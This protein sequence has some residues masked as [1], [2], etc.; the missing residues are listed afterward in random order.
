MTETRIKETLA[1]SGLG[2]G[3]S[4]LLTPILTRLY[5]P[6][7]YGLFAIINGVATVAASASQFSLTNALACATS[8]ATRWRLTRILVRL[9]LLGCVVTFFSLA[10]FVQ[11]GAAGSIWVQPWIIFGCPLLTFTI[12]AYR[13]AAS[14]SVAQGQFH[15]QVFARIGYALMAR[16]LAILF[17]LLFAPR[18]WFMVIAEAMAFG[19]QLFILSAHNWPRSAFRLISGRPSNVPAA[20]WRHRTFSL[21]DFPSQI[22][23]IAAQAVPAM[24]IGL[25][26]GPG[27]AG[28]LSVGVSLLSI[29]VQLISLAIAPALLYKVRTAWA[30]GSTVAVRALVRAF[31]LLSCLA[32]A[33]YGLLLLIAPWFVPVFLGRQWAE[34]GMLVR[35]LCVPFALQFITTP[36]LS[37]LWYSGH[38]RQKLAVDV[39]GFIAALAAL[40]LAVLGRSAAS[41]IAGWALV[42]TIQRIAELTLLAAGSRR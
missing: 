15:R 5:S 11:L 35:W 20:L 36:F 25:R 2:F 40:S 37:I 3:L 12:C 34:T 41:A 19:A 26:F 27:A 30:D 9:S 7:E 6:A 13:I 32:A 39:I 38:A 18:S 10:I 33:G 23:I 31:I 14:W 16:P 4:I 24:I 28:I 1:A 21:F 29:P 8:Q 42:L 22:L 17:G